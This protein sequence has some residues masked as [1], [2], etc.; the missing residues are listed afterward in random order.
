MQAAL[1][2]SDGV[3]VVELGSCFIVVL[4]GFERGAGMDIRST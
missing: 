3:E 2:L 4:L 1:R